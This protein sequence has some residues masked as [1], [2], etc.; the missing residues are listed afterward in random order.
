MQL[1]DFQKYR[2]ISL[3][4]EDLARAVIKQQPHLQKTLQYHREAS[5][6]ASGTQLNT[7]TPRA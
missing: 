5:P 1:I 6:S 4:S 7:P 3:A 2:I